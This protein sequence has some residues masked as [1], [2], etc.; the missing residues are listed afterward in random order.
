MDG[1]SNY[2]WLL[3]NKIDTQIR[4]VQSKIEALWDHVLPEE[5]N[6]QYTNY[7]LG[8]PL[9][10][11][12]ATDARSA[13]NTPPARRGSDAGSAVSGASGVVKGTGNAPPAPH[14]T[15]EATTPHITALLRACSRASRGA[16]NIPQLCSFGP[17][18]PFGALD[19]LGCV[20]AFVISSR[21]QVAFG[22]LPRP[23]PQ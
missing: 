3:T 2:Q 18:G 13:L 14:H 20:S 8:L 4:E 5:V 19:A 23:P 15:K 22:G 11:L 9:D 6:R 16:P 1:D 21:A 12:P 17:F 7:I 10:F